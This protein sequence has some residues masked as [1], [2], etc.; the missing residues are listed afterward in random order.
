MHYAYAWCVCIGM[1]DAKSYVLS[2][3]LR[4]IHCAATNCEGALHAAASHFDEQAVSIPVHR[5][6][7]S[8]GLGEPHS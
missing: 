5:R 7:A 1:H 3:H 6:A 8:V 2:A 4:K